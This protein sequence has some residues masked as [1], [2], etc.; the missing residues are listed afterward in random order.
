V[1]IDDDLF[2]MPPEVDIRR[3]K[4][5]GEIPIIL[6]D[7]IFKDPDRIRECALRLSYSPPP[8]AYPG[9]LAAIP[10]PNRSLSD[11][12]RKILGLVNSQYL[13][14]LPIA[15]NG[16][17]LLAFRNL[18]TDFGVVDVHPDELSSEQRVPHTDPVPVFGLIYLNREE[19]GGT[20]FFKQRQVVNDQEGDGGGYLT[21]SNPAF[22]L[23]G[24]IEPAYN[25]LAI[26]PGFVPHSGEIGGDWIRGPDRFSNPR[27]TQ[28]LV[29]LP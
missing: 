6:V 19:R 13:S 24:R 12:K 17:R 4:I 27:L 8:Y 10:E 28:R 14:Q 18:H 5:G 3:L 26:Y 7:G 11:L 23:L 16:Q 21:T 25:R 2:E 22:E 20:L 15:Q 1:T 29:F 9:R